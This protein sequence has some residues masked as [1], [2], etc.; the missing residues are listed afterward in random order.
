MKNFEIR[1]E[2]LIQVLS[3]QQHAQPASKLYELMRGGDT[4]WSGSLKSINRDLDYLE[5]EVL[6]QREDQGDGLPILWRI[7]KYQH[8]LKLLPIEAMT[9][10]AIFDHAERFGLKAHTEQL[11]DLRKFATR[12][13]NHQTRRG[14][15]LGRRIT[16]GTR[17]TLLKPGRYAPA[18]LHRIQLAIYQDEPLA[19]TYRPRDAD[20]ALCVY[21]LKPL[22]LSHQDS[23]TYLSALVAEEHWLDGYQPDP[24]RPRGKY[25]SNGPGELC[26]LMLHRIVEVDTGR[27]NIPDPDNYDVHSLEAQ[28]HLMTI[29]GDREIRL[30]LRLSANL[31]NRLWE[32]PLADDQKLEPE[33]GE[34]WRLS[35]DIL[36]SQGLRLFLMSNAADIEVIGPLELREHVRDQLLKAVALYRQ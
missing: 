16:S 28:R 24:D 29:H 36:D 31:Y 27:L 21:Q 7:S 1:R 8:E 19:V 14:I 30:E 12:A 17:F 2:R 15:D 23:N 3:R 22:A 9:L 13:M 35:C 32:N 18:L 20:D 6:V 4:E 11:T 10:S 33:G 34:H 5:S 26:A 25:G